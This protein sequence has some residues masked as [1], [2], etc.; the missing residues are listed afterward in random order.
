MKIK[1]YD[2][3]VYIKDGKIMFRSSKKVFYDSCIQKEIVYKEIK[4][5]LEN[6][7]KDISINSI[8][9]DAI[10]NATGC[11]HFYHYR[12]TPATTEKSKITKSDLLYIEFE[13]Y[14]KS[15]YIYRE[16]LQERQSKQ[17]RNR[18]RIEDS[19]AKKEVENNLYSFFNK[20]KKKRIKNSSKRRIS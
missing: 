4:N 7:P 20:E 6:N 2:D 9:S 3:H 17:Q 1:E 19:R 14:I 15:L 10:K 11:S 8:I 5:Y 12:I 13:E 16:I 18:K